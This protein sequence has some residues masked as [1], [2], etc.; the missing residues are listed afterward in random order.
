MD[1][2]MTHDSD[3]SSCRH[4]KRSSTFSNNKNERNFSQMPKQQ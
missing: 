1:G 4:S 3:D 2:T